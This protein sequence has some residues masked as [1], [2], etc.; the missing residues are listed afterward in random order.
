MELES[1]VEE[2][3]TEGVDDELQAPHEASHEDLKAYLKNAKERESGVEEEGEATQPN[4]AADHDDP[5]DTPPKPEKKETDPKTPPSQDSELKAAKERIERQQAQIQQ[6]ERYIKER[7]TEVG[8][9]RKSLREKEAE[10]RELQRVAEEEGNLG[11]AM[12]LR[13]TAKSLKAKG[14]QLDDE[15][16]RLEKVRV[17]HEIIPKF[18]EPYEFDL[19]AIK[20]ELIEAG[21][22]EGAAQ[23]FIDNI[24][25]AAHPETTVWLGKLAFTKKV[26]KRVLQR[27]LELQEE[28]ERLKAKAKNRGEQVVNGIRGA[29]SSQPMLSSGSSSANNS[30]RAPKGDPSTW[31]NEEIK[32][33]LKKHS[34]KK[35]GTD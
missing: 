35:H 11:E 4:I 19:P 6:Q 30:D 3:P 27:G 21:L 23:H 9:L 28:N 5:S 33:Y 34:T 18:L 2:G 17:A 22:K 20:E 10:V 16:E 7:S 1:A 12:E 13:D 31:S 29:L 15:A 24:Y 26:L 32:T 25:E 14:D 8:T